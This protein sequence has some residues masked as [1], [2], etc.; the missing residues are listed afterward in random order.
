M[1]NSF[2]LFTFLFLIIALTFSACQQQQKL[3]IS[4]AHN[5]SVQHALQLKTDSKTHSFISKKIKVESTIPTPFIMLSGFIETE[6]FDGNIYYRTITQKEWTDWQPFPKMVEGETPGRVVFWAGELDEK[7]KYVQIKSDETLPAPFVIRLYSP[8]HSKKSGNTSALI[9]SPESDCTCTQP[10]FCGRSCWCPNGDCPPDATPV[11]TVPKHIIVH[12]SAGQTNSTDF[13]AVVRSYWDY[14][15]NTKGWDDIGY[16]WLVDPNGIIYEG[17]GENRQGAHFSCMNSNTTGI[18]VIGNYETAIPANAAIESLQ[19]F[20]AWEACSKDIDVLGH[21]PHPISSSTELVNV[22]GH[23]D[24]NNNPASCTVT[25]C[26]GANLYSLL[27]SIRDQVSNEP[28]LAYDFTGVNTLLG[29]EK[30]SISPNPSRG[31]FKMNWENINVKTIV[32][33]NSV[34]QKIKDVNT[35]LHTDNTTIAIEAKG[36]YMLQIQLDDERVILEKIIIQ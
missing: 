17:R 1:K 25:V 22:A 36:V 6:D 15:V 28:C 12:H 18:C 32:I 23:R 2:N 10:S 9:R 27:P 24:G 21:S 19:K 31:V 33:F 29:N 35:L 30:I 8:G 5:N 14:H 16:N 4:P 20:I 13:S 11:A 3:I 7:T 34:G 26:P